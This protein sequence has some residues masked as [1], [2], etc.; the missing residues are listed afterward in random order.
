MNILKQIGFFLWSMLLFVAG[1]FT[2]K[3]FL[4][5]PE[6]VVTNKYDK[7][8]NKGTNNAISTESNPIASTTQEKKRF[9]LF[10]KRKK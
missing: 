6:T 7:I 3:E 4:D 2:Y 9:K 5:K 10:R 1:L 8:K